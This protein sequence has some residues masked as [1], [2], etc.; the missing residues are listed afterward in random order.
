MWRVKLEGDSQAFADLMNRWQQPI[1]NL[2][3]RMVGDVHRA[4]DLA[5]AAFVRLY[6]ARA[7][8][9]PDAKFSTFLWRIALNLC[10]DELRKL[11][12]RS[13]CSL[14]ELDEDQV[15]LHGTRADEPAPDAQLERK[16]L[17]EQGREA[18]LRLATHYR[19][20]IALR[21]YE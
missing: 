1:R 17:A 13:E 5:Q 2:C 21:H 16:E 4:E 15:S 20:V 9:Q 19:E 18:L 6:S 8:W 11:Q 7:S 10:H 14:D 12:R 3:T